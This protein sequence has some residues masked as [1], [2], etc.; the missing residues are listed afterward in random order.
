MPLR[1]LEQTQQE[2][3]METDAKSRIYNTPLTTGSTLDSAQGK[4]SVILSNQK[5]QPFFGTC[6]LVSCVNVLRMAG[7]T[8][9]T[10]K[11]VLQVA[12]RH[13]LCRVSADPGSCGGTTSK[14]RRNILAHFGLES[15]TIAP[16]VEAIAL[17]VSQGRGVII[18][19]DPG[20]LWQEPEYLNSF[21]AVTVTSVKE[22]LDGKLLGFY[23][24]DS[25]R[26]MTTDNARYCEADFL[27]AALSP[28]PM[29]VTASIIR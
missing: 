1:N 14:D 8:E 26:C 27:E 20:E 12:L 16:S 5:K 15:W 17:F 10:E 24:C 6:G 7:R 22:D 2:W 25:G 21:H 4:V 29:N 19:V 28:V 13:N 23:I 18:T 3:C 9:T 11:E